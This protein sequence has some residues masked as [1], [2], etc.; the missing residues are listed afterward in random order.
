MEWEYH[1]RGPLDP[2]SPFAQAA[3]GSRMQHGFGGS[4]SSD[5]KRSCAP[6]AD[7]AFTSGFGSPAATQTRHEPFATPSKQQLKTRPVFTQQ[8]A[9][10]RP[11][12][13]PFRNPAFTTP[14]KPVDE[15]AFSEA[16]GAEDSPAQTESDFPNDTPE[17]DRQGDVT[18]GGTITPSKVDKSLRYR[19]HASGKG[20]I[21]PGRSAGMD[22]A[23]RRKKQ[24]NPLQRYAEDTDDDAED[25]DGHYM[26]KDRLPRSRGSGGVVGAMFRMMDEH[27]DAPDNL[28]RWVKFGVNVFLMLLFCGAIVAV[29]QGVMSDIRTVHEDARNEIRAK[30]AVCQDEY[31]ANHCDT[32]NAPA[33]K[34]M[35]SEWL[36][37]MRQSE[38]IMKTRATLNEVANIMN[39]FFGRLNL[40]AWV[41]SLFL[42]VHR[43]DITDMQ[44]GRFHRVHRIHGHRQQHPRRPEPFGIGA[45]SR[46]DGTSAALTHGVNA[47]TKL[48]RCHVD[49]SANPTPAATHGNL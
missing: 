6:L 49:S 15:S 36:E 28:G 44:Q 42:R 46:T 43:M 1:S 35:C 18:M 37:C 12:A 7:L 48:G 22:L 26:K 41:C 45:V 30:A 27:R 20:E 34:K 5:L 4:S 33:F 25:S 14:R 47:A 23:R 39:D 19:K 32:T 8:Q 16:S 9:S 21:R 29:V 10:S 3:Q 31:M 11:T 2:T 40:K 17:I 24:H 13:P 38:D